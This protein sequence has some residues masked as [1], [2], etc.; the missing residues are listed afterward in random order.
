MLRR[1]WSTLGVLLLLR[2]QPVRLFTRLHALPWYRDTLRAWVDDLA[3]PA[4]ARVLEAGCASG[5]LTE[6]LAN[7]GRQ[8][9]GV[10]RA[11]AMIR[12]ARQR[13][14]ATT[15]YHVADATALPFAD[16]D[17]DAVLAAS[18]LNIVD[19]PVQLLH[20]LARVCRPGGIVTVLVPNREVAATELPNYLRQHALRGFSA[21]ALSTWMTRAPKMAPADVETLFRDVGLPSPQ[22]RTYLSGMLLGVSAR[23]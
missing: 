5:L 21:A 4:E 8:V 17:F 3:L 7:P 1:W 18:L 9:S 22:C 10:D 23:K 14:H 16:Q 15:N 6:Y 20:E 2:Y 12:A 11:A 13:G 19:A